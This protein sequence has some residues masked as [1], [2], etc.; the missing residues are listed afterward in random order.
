MPEP[1]TDHVALV[2]LDDRGRVGVVKWLAKD[3]NYK[4]YPGEDGS[5]LLVPSQAVSA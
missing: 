4:V 2:K 3:T 5:L 1:I